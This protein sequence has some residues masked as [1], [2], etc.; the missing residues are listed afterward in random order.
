MVVCFHL[1]IMFSF[2]YDMIIHDYD[3]YAILIMTHDYHSL[4][5]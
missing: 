5:P 3:A 2:I 1:A 4:F